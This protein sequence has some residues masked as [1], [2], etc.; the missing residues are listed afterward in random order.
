MTGLSHDP[1]TDDLEDPAV[2]TITRSTVKLSSSN[3]TG[4]TIAGVT[5]EALTAA[6]LE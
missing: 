2:E 3:S 6:G 1:G 4:I 5:A